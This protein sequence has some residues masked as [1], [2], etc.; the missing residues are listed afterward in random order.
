MPVKRRTAKLRRY[1][2]SEV[3]EA[4][5]T[6]QPLPAEDGA[7]GW[8][9]YCHKYCRRTGQLAVPTIEDYWGRLGQAITAEWAQEHPGT[10]PS[11]WWD[12]SSPRWDAQPD[13]CAA[14]VKV[15]GSGIP[16]CVDEPEW[17]MELHHF[18]YG[19][20]QLWAGGGAPIATNPPMFE[21]QA[22]YLERHRL[23]LPG[24]RKRLS[25]RDFQPECVPVEPT[26][27]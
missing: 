8:E 3:V 19:I 17:R 7:N 4:I 26:S 14:R 13:L 9:F 18:A 16:A 22:T 25:A 2:V 1:D 20:P 6:D 24:E 11:C 5:L 27:D 21:A 10:R 15:G 23:L 12:F